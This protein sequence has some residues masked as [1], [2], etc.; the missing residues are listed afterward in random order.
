MKISKHF[1]GSP[2]EA[3]VY[4]TWNV[5]ER[6]F[7]EIPKHLQRVTSATLSDYKRVTLKHTMSHNE[8]QRDTTSHNESQRDTTSHNESQRDTT[9]HN[10][11]Q[12]DTTTHNETQ[13]T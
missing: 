4:M 9:S 2:W 6:T 12:R 1:E 13:Q 11:S 8:S 7:I 10:Q 5:V 3:L